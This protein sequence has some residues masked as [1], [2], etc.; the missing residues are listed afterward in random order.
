MKLAVPGAVLHS[1]K[2]NS[3]EMATW[4]VHLRIAEKLSDLIES[5][6]IE[7]FQIGNLGPDLNIQDQGWESF[8]PPGDVTHFR[9]T[10]ED[11][12]WS[13]DLDFYRQYIDNQ[14]ELNNNSQHFSF[15][16]GY[17]FHL[18]TDNLWHKQ[19]GEETQT[20]YADQFSADTDF[21]WEVKRDWYGLDFKYLRAHPQAS[22]WLPF[23]ESEYRE[24]YL[25]FFPP[26][27]IQKKLANI[28][29]FYHRD[30]EQINK[31]LERDFIYLS[32]QTMDEFIETA[33]TRIYWI[34]QQL[35]ETN[36]NIN[37]FESALQIPFKQQSS[38]QRQY[39]D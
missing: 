29:A 28:K 12:F 14:Q 38:D 25:D 22:F 11:K 33:T 17:F 34:Y 16:L 27:I 37:D 20:R 23:L 7:Q 3:K 35:W 18:I 21:I 19:V 30:D 6:D 15:L 32:Q 10:P 31:L 9:N 36:T 8:E 2:S 4:I 39:P 24:D 5:I 1:T 26:E 13:S